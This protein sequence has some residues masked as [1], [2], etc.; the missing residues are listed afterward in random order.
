MTA[1]SA[2]TDA[3][4]AIE[5]LHLFATDIRSKTPSPS[6]SPTQSDFPHYIPDSPQTHCLI[7]TLPPPDL[8]PPA[9]PLE[10]CTSPS[11]ESPPPSSLNPLLMNLIVLPSPP[12][13][14]FLL[15]SVLFPLGLAQSPFVIPHL[16]FAVLPPADSHVVPSRSPRVLVQ[17]F[18]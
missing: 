3:L 8:P 13:S 6:P 2:L 7:A 18:I 10:Y 16:S 14:L 9:P 17:P 1:D 11:P 15:S 12:Q 5:N 4:N